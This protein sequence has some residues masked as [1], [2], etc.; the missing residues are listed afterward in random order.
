M[1]MYWALCLGLQK[2]C[3]GGELITPRTSDLTPTENLGLPS[4]RPQTP[5]YSLLGLQGTGKVKHP[6]PWDAEVEQVLTDT[7]M[8]RDVCSVLS[9]PQY[10]WTLCPYMG[11]RLEIEATGTI[12]T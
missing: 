10:P 3:G 5:G 6:Q 2:G 12:L 11:P 4:L 1:G 7:V 8:M 9:S